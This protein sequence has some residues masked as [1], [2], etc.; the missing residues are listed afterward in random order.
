MTIEN[1]QLCINGITAESLVEDYGSPL[2]VYDAQCI[3][4]KFRQFRAAFPYSNLDV[5][6][7]CKANTNLEILKLLRK[8][9][10]CI[11][12]V[13]T[14]EVFMALEA[15][16]PADTILFTGN[17]VTDEEMRY[18]IERQ[19]LINIDS[20][21][22]LERYGRM[23]PDT[24]MALRIN[25][26]VGSGHHDHCITGG[27]D[28]KFGMPCTSLGDADSLVNKYKLRVIGIHAHVGSGFLEGG[29]FLE[30]TETLLKVAEQFTTLQ[31][32]DCGGGFGIPYTLDE[33]P[34]EIN[35]LGQKLTDRF[36]EFCIKYGKDL[37]LKL[38][39][40]RYL[41]GE[42]G[43]LL[44]QCN[45]VK[46]NG[47]RRFVGTDSG[48]HH[49]I[50]KPLYNAHHEIVNASNIE[51]RTFSYDVCGNICESTDFF[52]HNRDISH[53]RE[54]DILAVKD[55]GAYGFCMSS[56]YNTRPRPAEVMVDEDGARLIRMRETIED[57]L[58]GQVG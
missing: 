39:P 19:I 11:D 17:N 54:G 33:V 15:G 7:A 35:T 49:L 2:Y 51:D 31:F 55:V 5:H 47:D 37:R 3:R 46:T 32:I 9:G 6:Y 10:A 18:F 34:L 38:E 16:Y 42:S 1:N 27:P 14:G 45:G 50:R 25:P 4:Q 28:S 13:S 20:I 29:P 24:D 21:S 12:A 43:T 30:A 22:Q 53:I 57:L 44:M 36:T 26:N 56:N 8:E 23:A 40:G 48:F 52:A 58:R 41:V